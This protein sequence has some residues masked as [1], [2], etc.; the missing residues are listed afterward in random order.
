FISEGEKV[1]VNTEDGKYQG[2]A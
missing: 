1:I 2:R